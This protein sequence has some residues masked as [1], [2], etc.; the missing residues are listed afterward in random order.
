M[1]RFFIIGAILL[2]LGTFVMP[3]FAHS[4]RTDE[5][6][7]HCCYTDE[8]YGEYHCH[9]NGR[10]YYPDNPKNCLV[11][12]SRSTATKDSSSNNPK[13]SNS[14]FLYLAAILG[15]FVFYKKHKKSRTQPK[16]V[17]STEMNFRKLSY[18]SSRWMQEKYCFCKGKT[19]PYTGK[20][21]ETYNEFKKYITEYQ[22]RHGKLPKF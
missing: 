11:A 22:N 10:T 21:I 4:G 6:G 1:R 8:C 17:V 9:D 5:N 19:N 3:I 13:K 18:P 7:C 12:S 15:G 16:K 20:K 14:S 2:F